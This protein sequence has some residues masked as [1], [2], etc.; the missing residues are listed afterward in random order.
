MRRPT[1]RA[2]S[3]LARPTEAMIH[4]T[5]PASAG[6]R[7]PESGRLALPGG[8]AEIVL[9]GA[10][11]RVAPRRAGALLAAGGRR[12][13]WRVG[14]GGG[15]PAGRR[16]LRGLAR[17][18]RR[19]RSGVG[20]GP[21][22]GDLGRTGRGAGRAA[23][24]RTRVGA[25]L[26]AVLRRTRSDR[27]RAGAGVAL[28]RRRGHL[29]RRRR[30]GLGRRRRAASARG[31]AR[32]RPGSL[33]APPASPRAGHRGSPPPAAPHDCGGARRSRTPARRP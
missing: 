5:G 4:R 26:A 15:G 8:S 29:L 33:R 1:R 16:R 9:P 18:V 23:C 20:S 21:A 6:R 7:Q 19:R 24:A 11:A 25:R 14:A 31:A 13:R 22:A 27:R 3:L 32:T 2:D 30:G 17:A 10:L 12:E 28:L